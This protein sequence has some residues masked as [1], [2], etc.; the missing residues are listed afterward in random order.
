MTGI[1]GPYSF[2]DTPQDRRIFFGRSPEIE[3]LSQQI[4]AARLLV[5][6]GKSGLGKTSLLQAGVFPAPA[7]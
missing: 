3:L 6:F 4:I 1:R 5:L 7:G 2:D